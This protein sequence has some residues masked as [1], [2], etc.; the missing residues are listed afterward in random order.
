MRGQ[1]RTWSV[2]VL[3]WPGDWLVVSSRWLTDGDGICSG[4][5]G[6]LEKI[7]RLFIGTE[8]TNFKSLLDIF[9]AV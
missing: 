9:F 7:Q 2:V 5:I 3:P 8:F 1:C 4:C 6:S